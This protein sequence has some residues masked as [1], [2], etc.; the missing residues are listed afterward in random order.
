MQGNPNYE[1][2]NG[3]W[4]RKPDAPD[5]KHKSRVDWPRVQSVQ[6]ARQSVAELREQQN[7]RNEEYRRSH[8][9]G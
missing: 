8:G 3:V 1:L 2:V 9:H 7:Q 5:A 6:N 4:V